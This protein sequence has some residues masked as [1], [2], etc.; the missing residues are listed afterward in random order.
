MNSLSRALSLLEKWENGTDLPPYALPTM[1]RGFAAQLR[2]A[3]Q[4][5]DHATR[6][7]SAEGG[8]RWT[9]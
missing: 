2:Q 5:D 1:A 8:S 4:G 3:L 7:R 9:E 6:G